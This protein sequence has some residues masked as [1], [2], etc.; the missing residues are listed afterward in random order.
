MTESTRNTKNILI[1]E[2]ITQQLLE[3]E[4]TFTLGQFFK[5]IPDLK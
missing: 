5:I 2:N 1:S 4:H 3:S